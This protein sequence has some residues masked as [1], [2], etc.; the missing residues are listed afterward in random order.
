M[1]AEDLGPKVLL[2]LTTLLLIAAAFL[3][4]LAQAR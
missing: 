1:D 4:A 2:G 3:H